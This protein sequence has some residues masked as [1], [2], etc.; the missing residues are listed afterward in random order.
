MRILKQEVFI[1]FVF[2]FLWAIEIPC[3][4]KLSMKKFKASEPVRLKPNCLSATESSQSY[5]HLVAVY[6]AVIQ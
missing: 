6:V 3:S 5:E 4:V 1:F 2:E